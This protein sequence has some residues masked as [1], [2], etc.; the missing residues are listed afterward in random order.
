MNIGGVFLKAADAGLQLALKK[1]PTLQTLLDHG[2]SVVQRVQ[3]QPATTTLKKLPKLSEIPDGHEI[4][5]LFPDKKTKFTIMNEG[6]DRGRLN[7]SF[8]LSNETHYNVGSLI[9][10]NHEVFTN[11]KGFDASEKL[12]LDLFMDYAKYNGIQGQKMTLS[13]ETLHAD[14]S[15]TLASMYKKLTEKHGMGLVHD[16]GESTVSQAEVWSP[17]QL[18]ETLQKTKS[19]LDL[20]EH[21][22]PWMALSSW[23][24]PTIKILDDV[25]LSPTEV[26]RFKRLIH[27]EKG[28]NEKDLILIGEGT[29]YKGK[30]AVPGYIFKYQPHEKHN[31]YYVVSKPQGSGARLVGSMELVDQPQNLYLKRMDN[32][33]QSEH[34]GVGK[35]LHQIAQEVAEQKQY[36]LIRLEAAD[37]AA[38]LYHYQQGY[39]MPEPQ[40]F[41]K[42]QDI[43][44]D[45][46]DD[47]A[48]Y[49]QKQDITRMQFY[50]QGI[51]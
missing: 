21:Y 36:P 19:H 48:G 51:I 26:S 47:M 3:K 34:R 27:G 41:F 32:E 24:K 28:I 44:P 15:K 9:L 12:G 1:S 37:G 4:E 45:M 18:H 6:E 23:H 31:F 35:L 2:A 46:L 49:F 40:A 13:L 33:D 39:R 11:F 14:D 7:A 30:K 8:M 10:D 17:D 20:P 29:V 5:V 42:P 16:N 22:T 25:D 50:G 43:M 38:A